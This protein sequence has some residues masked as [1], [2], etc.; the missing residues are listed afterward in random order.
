MQRAWNKLLVLDLDDTLI[1]ARSPSHAALPWPPQ[2]M[3]ERYR[4]YLRPGAREFVGWAREHFAG[5]GVWTSANLA[6]ARA[7]LACLVDPQRLDLLWT[8]EQCESVALPEGGVA[9]TKPMARLLALGWSRAQVLVVD[10]KPSSVVGG[11]ASV[12]AMP[13]FEGDPRDRELA[14]LQAYLSE[15]GPLPNV[16]TVD[17][18]GWSA[19][20]A[21]PHEFDLALDLDDE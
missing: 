9:W 15:L 5:L 19:K 18:R 14:R 16:A 6:Y 10:D 7:M 11:E 20:V 17:K 1:H 2:R 21:T 3:I 13:R 4:V 12:I 8:R